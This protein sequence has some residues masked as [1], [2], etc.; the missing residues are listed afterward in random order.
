MNPHEYI[1][2]GFDTRKRFDDARH[3]ADSERTLEWESLSNK[4]FRWLH[5]FE[6][7]VKHVQESEE[8]QE[9]MEH[10]QILEDE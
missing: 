6:E 10:L 8:Y 4:A 5:G 3:K 9:L 7:K 1:D 2:W